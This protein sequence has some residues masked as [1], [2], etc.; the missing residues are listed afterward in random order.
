[1]DLRGALIIIQQSINIKY[2]RFFLVVIIL[3]LQMS[4]MMKT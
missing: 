3:Y 2:Q 1:M 4:R